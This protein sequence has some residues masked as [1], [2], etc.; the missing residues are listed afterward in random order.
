[1]AAP[2]AFADLEIRILEKQGAKGYPVEFTLNRDREFP[3]GYP[4][5]ATHPQLKSL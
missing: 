3:R 2:M 5:P 4:D 1:M